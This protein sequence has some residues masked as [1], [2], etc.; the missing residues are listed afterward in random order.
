M[1]VLRS[2]TIISPTIIGR[3]V[4]LAVLTDLVTQ[5]SRGQSRVG[6][7]AGEA[8]IGKSRLIAEV[9]AIA[10]QHGARI[11]QAHCFEH[12][13]LLPFAPLIDLLRA[14]CLGRS[15]DQLALVFGSTAAE[16]VKIYPELSASL[17]NLTSTPALDPEQEKRRLFQAIARFLRHQTEAGQ[18]LLLVLEDLH[19]CDDT[20]LEWLLYF[21]R[22][23]ETQRLLVL[24]TYRNDE[25]HPTLNHLLA[26]LDRMSYIDEVVLSALTRAEVE[27]MLRAIFNLPTAPRA[28]FLDTLYTLTDGN[29]LFIE[30][31]LKSLIAAGDIY[32][33]G[34]AW[35]RKPLSELHIPRTVQVAVQQRTRQLNDADQRLL[36]LAAVA[37]QRFDFTVLQTVTQQTESE[38]LRQMK[39]LLAAQLVIEETDETFAFRHALTR[40]AIYSALL[41]R[42]RK[43]LHR[44]VAEA[45]EH[46]YPDALD[47][48]ASDLA[49]HCYEAGLWAQALHWALCAGDNAARLYAH[50]EAVSQY[51]R[52][53]DCAE[54]LEQPDQVAAVDRAIGNVYDAR[55]EYQQAIEAYAR[56]QCHR[57]PGPAELQWPAAYK[58]IV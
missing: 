54:K 55:G 51:T 20:S 13:R 36:T 32:Q 38:L 1:N 39:D 16:L 47:S 26:A 44:A 5:V 15:T 48:H 17:P 49:Y 31:V 19:W 3:E 29:P 33:E 52:A 21:A 10:E 2:P 14:L 43:A 35:T 50:G 56:P 12:E 11:V 30:E 57:R 45:L 27:T 22:E 25:I 18:P 42:E 46:C 34:G 40:Q 8:G 23:L 24:L 6:L 7:I 9:A 41:A 4:Q 53:R 58:T 28:D 37:G